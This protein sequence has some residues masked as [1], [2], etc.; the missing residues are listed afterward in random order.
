MAAA[1]V[2]APTASAAAAAAPVT[3][4]ISIGCAGWSVTPPAG[5]HSTGTAK[6]PVSASPAWTNDAGCSGYFTADSSH[7]M[8]C[9]ASAITVNN[10]KVAI[11]K[12][13]WNGSNGFGWAKAF[14]YHNL[15]MQPMID[16]ISGAL[17][18]GG[19]NSSRN[20]EVYH[21]NHDGYEDMEVVVVADIQDNWFQQTSTV[22]LKALGVLT[23]YCTSPAEQVE[24]ACPDWVDEGPDSL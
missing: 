24:P 20:Y 16:T 9:R 10:F 21:Y 23:G 12:G 3:K 7:E 6:T 8:Y 22:D 19:S 1:F 14:Y 4:S 11:R 18:P 5:C 2:A 15:W 13:F 17:T